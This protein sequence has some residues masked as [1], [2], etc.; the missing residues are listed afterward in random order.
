MQLY[1]KQDWESV[2]IKYPFCIG[3]MTTLV[4]HQA[5][6]HILQQNYAR[7]LIYIRSFLHG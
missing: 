1:K 2:F 3:P 5:V 4:S 7:D 6:P